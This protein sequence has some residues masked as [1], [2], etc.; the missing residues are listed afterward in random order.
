MADYFNR[1]TLPFNFVFCSAIIVSF[2][3][4]PAVRSQYLT[5]AADLVLEN[6]TEPVRFKRWDVKC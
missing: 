6:V 1:Q 2:V 5:V 3:T 4:V